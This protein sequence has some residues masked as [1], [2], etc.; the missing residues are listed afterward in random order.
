[1]FKA[2]SHKCARVCVCVFLSFSLTC[3]PRVDALQGS[4]SSEAWP[5]KLGSFDPLD[6]RTRGVSSKS[7]SEARLPFCRHHRERE[8][9]R[10]SARAWED[11]QGWCGEKWPRERERERKERERAPRWLSLLRLFFCSS[12]FFLPRVLLPRA[13]VCVR[14]VAGCRSSEATRCSRASRSSCLC[15][16]RASGRVLPARESTNF[17]HAKER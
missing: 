13:F 16:T 7:S 4:A 2:V 8:R 3:H 10:E 1:M 15:T 9:E 12:L 6:T 14:A 17:S 5:L 11:P